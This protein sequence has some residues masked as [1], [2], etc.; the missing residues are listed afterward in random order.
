MLPKVTKIER[1]EAWPL[2]K[3]KIEFIKIEGKQFWNNNLIGKHVLI[4]KYS[5]AEHFWQIQLLWEES[6]PWDTLWGFVIFFPLFSFADN[7]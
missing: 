5:N 1:D 6:F 3:E 2:F 4:L 7:G